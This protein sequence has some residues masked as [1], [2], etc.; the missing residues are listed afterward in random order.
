MNALTVNRKQ[1]LSSLEKHIRKAADQIQKNG[2]EIGRD[3]IEIRDDELW[4]EEYESWNQYL[5]DRAAELVGRSFTAAAKLIQAA[6]VEKRLP[7]N[8]TDYITPTPTHIR[9]IGRLAP[10]SG[11]DTGGREKDYSKLRKKDVE[12]VLKSASKIAG[13][14]EVSVRDIRKAVDDELG[15]DRTQPKRQV[16]PGIDIDVFLRDLAEHCDVAAKQLD[17]LAIE[18]W[19]ALDENHPGLRERVAIACSDLADF[20]RS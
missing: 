8:I 20:L 15:V 5:K 1:R 7:G 12:K 10:F 17:G 9:E 3:L 4:A 13:N 11:K 14:G 6:E 18:V 19:E 2:L 16:Q